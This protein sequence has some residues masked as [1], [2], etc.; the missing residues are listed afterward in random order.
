M[1]NIFSISIGVINFFIFSLL[2]GLL[3]IVLGIISK[4]DKQKGAILGIILNTLGTSLLLASWIVADLTEGNYQAI[5]TA[6]IFTIFSVTLK[7]LG[8]LN[9]RNNK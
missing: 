2:F 8:F 3:G 6:I 4:R 1:F 9:S 7:L 5:I